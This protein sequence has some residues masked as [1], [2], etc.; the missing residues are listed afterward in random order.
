MKMS[1][2][3]SQVNIGGNIIDDDKEL[4]VNDLPNISK[5]LNLYLFADDTNIYESNRGL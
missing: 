2:K 4:Y 5:V 3:P 1:S